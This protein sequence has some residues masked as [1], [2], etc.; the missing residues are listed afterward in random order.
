MGKKNSK[1]TG[2]V[3]INRTYKPKVI[4]MKIPKEFGKMIETNRKLLVEL[5]K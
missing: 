3:K 2:K 4:R 5:S 1:N